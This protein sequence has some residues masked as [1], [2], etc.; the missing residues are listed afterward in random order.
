MKRTHLGRF[1]LVLVASLAT[2]L[3]DALAPAQ[4]PDKFT[5]LK[6]L[7]KDISKEDLVATMRGFAGG[8][9]VRCN[10]CHVGESPND[11]KGMDFASDDKKEKGIARAMLTMVGE[12]NGTLIP[13]TGI[14]NPI[15]V[16]C[17]TCHHGVEHPET[18]ADI[19]KREFAKG[20]V[21]SV[22]TEYLALKEKY[23]GADAYNFKSPTL[24]SLAEWLAEEQ[25]NPEAAIAIMQFNIEQEPNVAYSYNLLGRIQAAAGKKDDAIA[26]LKKA[27]ELNPEDKWSAKVLEQLQAGK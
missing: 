11:L 15:Q 26:S 27:I 1:M 6:V 22:K 16:K 3:C 19:S 20:G 12:I 9:G 24:N 13:K 21:D 10:H 17:A 2:L 4:I 7:P 18:L 14:E 23:Y 25:D 5:N 8:L